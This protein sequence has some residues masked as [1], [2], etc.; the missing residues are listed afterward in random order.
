MTSEMANRA[1][2]LPGGNPLP[3]LL[4]VPPLPHI[5][6]A[7]HAHHDFAFAVE[8]R[9]FRE[10]F[11]VRHRHTRFSGELPNRGRHARLH[12]TGRQAPVHAT[13][14]TLRPIPTPHH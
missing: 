3:H 7:H 1:H 9:F 4:P 10:Q 12:T 14:P 8:R 6:G 11:C 2:G 5:L 13:P